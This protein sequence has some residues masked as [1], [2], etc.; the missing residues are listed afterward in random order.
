VSPLEDSP[1][2]TNPSPP[3]QFGQSLNAYNATH[4]LLAST[5]PMIEYKSLKKQMKRLPTTDTSTIPT[6]L[7]EQCQAVESTFVTC[8]KSLCAKNKGAAVETRYS[9]VTARNLLLYVRINAVAVRK[10][11]KKY[12]KCINKREKGESGSVEDERGRFMQM[13]E[14][15]GSDQVSPLTNSVRTRGSYT[16][17][18]TRPLTP[19]LGH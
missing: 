5:V 13:F 15:V 2:F 11:I 1:C 17:P 4:P 7:T 12:V 8:Y 10:C 16:Q 19:S 9:D 6:R 3:L 18:H 14:S